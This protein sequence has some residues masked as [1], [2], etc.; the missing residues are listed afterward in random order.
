MPSGYTA[1]HSVGARMTQ[2]P[3]VCRALASVSHGG[4]SIGLCVCVFVCVCACVCVCVCLPTSVRLSV[5]VP[6]LCVCF[7][8]CVCVCALTLPHYL[9]CLVLKQRQ[10]N[11]RT[12]SSS[13]RC[14]TLPG[15][16]LHKQMG[17]HHEFGPLAYL[18]APGRQQSRL[19]HPP[20]WGSG[21]WRTE[22]D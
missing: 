4:L 14:Q 20:W 7:P 21:S 9:C 5:F 6:C 8:L 3:H 16:T 12:W 22:G 19:R 17:Y 10:I 2:W 11:A 13:P 1:Y 18:P 15:A